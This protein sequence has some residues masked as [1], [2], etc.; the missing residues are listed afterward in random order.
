MNDKLGELPPLARLLF[1]GLWCHADRAGRLE[2]RPKKLKAEILPY[3][4]CDTNELLDMLHKAGLILRYSVSECNYIQVLKFDKHQNPHVRE[5]ESSIP[6]PDEHSANTGQVQVQHESGPADSLLLI[7]DS[8]SPISDGTDAK[9]D[10]FEELRKSYPKREGDNRLKDARSAYKA[11]LKEGHTKDEILA[12]VV[13]YASWVRSKGKEG[14]EYVKQLATFLGPGKP[15]LEKWEIGSAQADRS[16]AH[17]V[18]KV[19]D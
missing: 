5:P 18:D 10:G 13:R 9:P 12:G 19:K 7:P 11:R 3:D 1:A 14:T 2:D 15:F 17:L 16:Y 8:P 6:A 4:D